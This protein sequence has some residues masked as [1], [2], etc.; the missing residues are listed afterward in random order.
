M[1]IKNA[2]LDRFIDGNA[3]V[4]VGVEE[5]EIEVPADLLPENSKEGDRL[6][7]T[8]NQ[9]QFVKVEYDEQATHSAR[10][11]ICRKMEL[12]RQRSKKE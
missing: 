3:I 8:F 12:L 11:R 2:V 1:L 10:E 6:I 9:H 5:E 7:I 4:L